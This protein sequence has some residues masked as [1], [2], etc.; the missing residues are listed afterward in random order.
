MTALKII[1][2]AALLVGFA[3]LAVVASKQ[4]TIYNRSCEVCSTTA[5]ETKPTVAKIENAD[6]SDHNHFVIIFAY[7]AKGILRKPAMSHVFALFYETTDGGL[8]KDFSISWCQVGSPLKPGITKGKN[9]EVKETLEYAAKNDLEVQMWGPYSID[10]KF[11]KNAVLRYNDL[12]SGKYYY[13]TLDALNRTD[14]D[15]PAVN[16]IH[17]VSD[18]AGC[19]DTEGRFGKDAAKCIVEKFET[20]SVV[21]QQNNGRD[22]CHDEVIKKLGVQVRSSGRSK[23]TR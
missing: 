16:N 7:D 13:R 1:A 6:L 3:S 17:A 2:A 23:Y 21:S 10:E 18:V 5:I 4:Q 15:R 19:I 9:L 20:N 12:S 22:T 11:Y 8:R 14:L